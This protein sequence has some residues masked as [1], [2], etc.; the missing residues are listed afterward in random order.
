MLYAVR[1]TDYSYFVGW[2]PRACGTKMRLISRKDQYLTDGQM[3]GK[4]GY[5]SDLV[6]HG[7]NPVIQSTR[8]QDGRLSWYLDL[9]APVF[10]PYFLSLRDTPFLCAEAPSK[11]SS[12]LTSTCALIRGRLKSIISS[13]ITGSSGGERIC[14]AVSGPTFRHW[15]FAGLFWRIEGLFDGC[16]CCCLPLSRISK[17]S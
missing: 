10:F 9:F 11:A 1:S 8:M 14:N 2:H 16:L 13:S 4:A 15:K 7:S 6:A 17:S 5:Q 12:Y 3:D